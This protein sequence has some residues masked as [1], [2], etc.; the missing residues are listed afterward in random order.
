MIRHSAQF[1]PSQPVAFTRYLNTTPV[2][3]AQ[4]QTILAN[5]Q[6]GAAFTDHMVGMDWDERQGWHNARVEPYG[7]IAMMPSAVVFHYGQEIFEGLKAYR[8]ADGSIWTFRPQDNAKRFQRSAHRLSLPELPVD[9]FLASLK[10]IV[11]VDNEWVPGAEGQSL[12]LRPFMFG[13]EAFLGVRSAR[14][15]RF[16]VIASPAGAYFRGGNDSVSIWVS[17]YY[18]RAGK[19]GTG[20]AK[21]GGNYAASLLPQGQALE[22]GCD[23]TLFLD[24]EGNV[25][26]CGSMNIVFVMSD[27]TVVTPES[28]TILPGIT[29]ESL[30]QL[31]EDRGMKVV[32]R[33]VS[34]AEWREGVASG[35]VREVFACGTAA[36]VIPI[37]ELCGIDGGE[38]FR[39]Q[40][41]RG[42]L[43]QSLRDEL[44]GIQMGRDDDRHGWLYRLDV[45]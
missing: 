38:E 21:C 11:D 16:H 23:Q 15:A 33:S 19:G 5:P 39:E 45:D 25:D 1:L 22:H 29:R 10:Q 31:A 40:Q 27:G 13:S 17:D 34:L 20:S 41:P 43:A 6:F 28:D 8:H 18:R 30:L 32:R 42:E 14:E 36:V 35:S 4:R 7:P 9:H 24:T 26:E 3:P 2:P 12:Y 37:R 44:V